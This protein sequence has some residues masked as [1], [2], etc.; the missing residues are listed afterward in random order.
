MI[1]DLCD[2]RMESNGVPGRI[3]VSTATADHLKSSGKEGWLT[4]REEK[5]VVK[6]KGEMSTFFVLIPANTATTNTSSNF[7]V[8]S[9][10]SLNES[11]PQL[12]LGS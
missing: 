10:K 5:I 1:L 12:D 6:G 3:H 8:G 7:T 2:S 4:A 9:D 11:I